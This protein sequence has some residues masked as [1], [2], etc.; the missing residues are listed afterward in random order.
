MEICVFNIRSHFNPNPM[1]VW[2]YPMHTSTRGPKNWRLNRW[3][4]GLW[5]C[6]VTMRRSLDW[7][8]QLIKRNST[9]L[10]PARAS[11]PGPSLRCDSRSSLHPLLH[12]CRVYRAR[13]LLSSLGP[14]RPLLVCSFFS[15]GLSPGPLLHLWTLLI[16]SPSPVPRFWYIHYKL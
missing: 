5:A 14:G 15:P 12:L 4:C 9:H 13:L 6:Q 11:C 2:M 3:P 7:L 1:Y 16:H 8:R 10:L